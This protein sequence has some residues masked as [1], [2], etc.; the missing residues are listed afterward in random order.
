MT[1]YKTHEVVK[2][3]LTTHPQTRNSDNYLYVEVC[4]KINP[5]CLVRSFGDVLTRVSEY[6]LPC[7]ETVTR[8]RRK[9][10]ATYPEL[11]AISE[12]EA[13]RILNEEEYRNYARKVIL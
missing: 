3:I 6:N 4:R 2:E 5:D 9:I 13:I 1:I 7:F 12:V 11:A 8:A 10:Q